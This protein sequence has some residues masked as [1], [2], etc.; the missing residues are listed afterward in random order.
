MG[1]GLGKRNT[2]LAQQEEEEKVP[3]SAAQDY[4]AQYNGAPQEVGSSQAIQFADPMVAA[5]Q[6]QQQQQVALAGVA[7]GGSNLPDE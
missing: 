6:L 2:M 7:N 3:S 1:T 4:L 5:Q